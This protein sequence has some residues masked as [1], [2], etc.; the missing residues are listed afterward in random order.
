[1]GIEPNDVPLNSSV[2]E[3]KLY[4]ILLFSNLEGFN[5]LVIDSKVNKILKPSISFKRGLRNKNFVGQ[6]DLS[7]ETFSLL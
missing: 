6:P 2:I 1:V 5:P 3:F 4:L 7:T